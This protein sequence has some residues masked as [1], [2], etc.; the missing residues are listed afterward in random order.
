MKIFGFN[1]F[2]TLNQFYSLEIDLMDFYTD[3]M[4]PTT[5]SDLGLL[6]DF[7]LSSTVLSKSLSAHFI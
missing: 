1:V 6:T 7:K 4:S 3:L 2:K 5:I